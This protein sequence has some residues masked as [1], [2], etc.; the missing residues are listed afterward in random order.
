MAVDGVCGL[1]LVYPAKNRQVGGAYGIVSTMFFALY[2]L[3]WNLENAK[4]G[5]FQRVDSFSRVAQV[6]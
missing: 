5:K 1:H 4:L 2:I 6:R 3:L